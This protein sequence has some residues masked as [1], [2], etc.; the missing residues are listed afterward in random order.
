MS[1][2]VYASLSGASAAWT[3]LE[4]VANNMANATTSG[5]KASRVAFQAVGPDQHPLGEGYAV[6]RG[7]GV[8][9]RDG[10][11]VSDSVPTHLALQGRGWFVLDNGGGQLLTR[12]GHF[13]VNEDGQ[14]IHASGLPVLGEGGPIEVP[15]GETL[16]IDELG[17]IYGSVSGELDRVRVVDGPVTAVG[18]NL[19]AA[20]GDLVQGDARVI[21]GALEASN[22]DP[23]A[24][25]VDLVQA[26]RL[27]ET[28][29]K[30]MQ[31]SDE[32]DERLN[33]VGGH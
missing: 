22:V 4:V 33:R 17:T 13:T 8:D 30:A 15:E 28:Y 3:Q 6:S 20:D 19:F 21:Q 29:Q 32:L 24:V 12:D 26:G 31:A 27:F 10:A 16:R 5:F 11:L 18:N 9:L 14:L 2:D 23:L 7:S 1:R 25:M